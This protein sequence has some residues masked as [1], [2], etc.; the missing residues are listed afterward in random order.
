MSNT[1]Q[2][3][4]KRPAHRLATTPAWRRAFLVSLCLNGNASAAQLQAALQRSAATLL[5]T[6]KTHSYEVV[7][8]DGLLLAIF[9]TRL[10]S[11]FGH[12]HAVG[13]PAPSDQALGYDLSRLSPKEQQL[14]LAITRKANI[15]A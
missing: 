4:K 3:H 7:T 1:T 6:A 12:G 13:A 15:Q 5:P 8:A 9:K 10:P 2:F 14:L 11:L